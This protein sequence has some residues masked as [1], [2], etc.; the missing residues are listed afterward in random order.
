MLI[1][2]LYP[3][4]LMSKIC[5]NSSPPVVWISVWSTNI[6]LHLIFKT[7]VFQNGYT[8]LNCDAEHA[9]HSIFSFFIYFFLCEVFSVCAFC[10]LSMDKLQIISHVHTR[11]SWCLYVEITT[12]TLDVFHTFI[13]S[14]E[15]HL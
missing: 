1:C 6:T 4:V 13:I 8:I 3:L 11:F 2:N 15:G 7:D 14:S 9:K 12:N 10:M 5:G